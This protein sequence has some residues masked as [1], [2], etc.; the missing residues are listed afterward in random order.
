M[1]GVNTCRRVLST[2]KGW[3]TNADMVPDSA[4]EMKEIVRG[5]ALGIGEVEE[6]R[7]VLKISNPAQYIPV[8]SA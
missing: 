5:D 2:S 4:P 3:V 6:E 7:L 8:S 1:L